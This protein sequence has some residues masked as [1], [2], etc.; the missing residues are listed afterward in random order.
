MISPGEAGALGCAFLWALNGLVLRSQVG[1][2]SPA[3][4]NAWRCMAGG[5]P[6]LL[7]LPFDQPLVA[8]AALP[9][10]DWALLF[11]SLV[12]GPTIGATLYITSLRELGAARAMPLTGTYPLATLLFEY[13]L[14][15]TPPTGE[16]L[17]GTAL[18]VVGIVLLSRQ[19]RTD[20]ASAV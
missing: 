6:F 18:V 13:L 8:F 15:G 10:Q 9:W 2:M 17:A 11:G 7:L 5:L 12:A 19:Q 14:L 1:A 4:M 20:P 3:A 16:V